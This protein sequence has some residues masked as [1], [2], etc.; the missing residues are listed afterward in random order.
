MWVVLIRAQPP[1]SPPGYPGCIVAKRTLLR[2]GSI[3]N[4]QALSAVLQALVSCSIDEQVELL[5][6]LIVSA[7]HSLLNRETI[8][9]HL[10][11][12]RLVRTVPPLS[13]FRPHGTISKSSHNHQSPA[14]AHVSPRTRESVM[15]L[16][17]QYAGTAHTARTR[18][19]CA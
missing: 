17:P 6:L 11:F 8:S 4:P 5:S 10:S 2:L 3:E 9:R 15:R 12:E 14:R 19:L 1:L 16:Y 13:A 7:T 18:A